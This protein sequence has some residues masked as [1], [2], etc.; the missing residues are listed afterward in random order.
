MAKHDGS[1]FS[2][3]LEQA[4]D[5]FNGTVK[6]G[7]KFQEDAARWWT[8]AWSPSTGTLQD[9]QRRTQAIWSEAMPI[10]QRNAD[11]YLR[12]FDA[13]Y[14]TGMGLAKK[15][16]DAGRSESVSDAQA[17]VQQLLDESIGALRNST[18]AM[19]EANMQ[20]MQAWAGVV[21]TGMQGVAQA[22]REAT[23]TASTQAENIASHAARS[24]GRKSTRPH[25]AG[26]R[27]HA[28]GGRHHA[29]A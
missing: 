9:L 13:S 19:A 2:E 23:S 5:T 16:L 28:A 27:H 18:K 22:T 14:R 11:E 26:G 10:A 3:L 7:V 25:A 4:M 29:G 15:A 1:G 17:K 6:A 12:L 20:M 24:A 21:R 8:G